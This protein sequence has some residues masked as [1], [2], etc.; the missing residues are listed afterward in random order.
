M[1]CKERNKCEICSMSFITL[2]QVIHFEIKPII[3]DALRYPLKVSRIKKN[4]CHFHFI[5]FSRYYRSKIMLRIPKLLHLCL[6]LSRLVS[7]EGIH[8]GI[9]SRQV[10]AKV[11]RVIVVAQKLLRGKRE[12]SS[13]EKLLCFQGGG[14]RSLLL[15]WRRCHLLKVF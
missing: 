2:V 5:Y 4:I 3:F 7:R 10:V 6:D 13:H 1:E 9:Q 14:E 11:G 8:E 12:E 15:T